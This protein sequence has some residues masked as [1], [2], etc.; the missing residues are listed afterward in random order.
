V[1]F[2]GVGWREYI[3][4]NHVDNRFKLLFGHG[5]TF[6]VLLRI[7]G[8]LYTFNKEM[9]LA[10][11]NISEMLRMFGQWLKLFICFIFRRIILRALSWINLVLRTYICKNV[12][13]QLIICYLY[14]YFGVLQ[15][16]WESDFKKTSTLRQY[17]SFFTFHL[18]FCDST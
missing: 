1:T 12:L 17:W 16:I 15:K 3:R 4:L 8:E 10:I 7:F 14:Y 11:S 5:R 18:Y 2:M 6:S 13:Y 9:C